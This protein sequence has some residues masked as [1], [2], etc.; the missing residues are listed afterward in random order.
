MLHAAFGIYACR[1]EYGCLEK[2]IESHARFGGHDMPWMEA[3]YAIENAD[4]AVHPK[5]P[6]KYGI[7][8]VTLELD[9]DKRR[10]LL[11]CWD[12]MPPDSE[13]RGVRLDIKEIREGL[14]WYRELKAKEYRKDQQQK[15]LRKADRCL[16]YCWIVDSDCERCKRFD[17]FSL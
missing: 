15:Q 8:G 10:S 7:M 16:R 6:H 12:Y 5:Q 17:S 1:C 11:A 3:A 9:L 14:V 2:L 13:L 4:K